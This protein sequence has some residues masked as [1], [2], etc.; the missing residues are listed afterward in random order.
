MSFLFAL[1][2]ENGIWIFIFMEAFFFFF[3]SDSV[4][5]FFKKKKRRDLVCLFNKERV[6]LPLA[7]SCVEQELKSYFTLTPGSANTS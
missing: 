2:Y 3:L 6:F 5:F 1:H 4:L 7:T